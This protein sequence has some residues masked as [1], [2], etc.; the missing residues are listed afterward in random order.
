MRAITLHDK[1]DDDIIG[2][3]LI[4]K[5]ISF[6]QVCQVWDEYQDE[7]NSNSKNIP[8]I[9]EF[10]DKYSDLCEALDIDF[11]QPNDND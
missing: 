9:Y 5:N 8:D 7:N 4:K 2:T 3:V 6:D 10:A 1:Y 11:Y